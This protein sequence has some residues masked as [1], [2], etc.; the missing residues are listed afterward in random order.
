MLPLRSI[1]ITLLLFAASLFIS[2]T[3]LVPQNCNCDLEQECTNPTDGRLPGIWDDATCTCRHNTPVIIDLT[4]HGFLLTSKAN[5]VAFDIDADGHKEDIAWTDPSA[6][7]AFL[8]LDRNANG[9][10][11]DG[12]ELFGNVTPQPL[13]KTPN[14]FVAL[15][16]F[17]KPENG[18]NSDG[19][20]DKKDAV[21][22]RLRLWIDRNHDGISQPSELDTLNSHGIQSISLNYS[23]SMKRDQFGNLFRFRSRIG[24]SKQ[25]DV[26]RVAYDV[27]LATE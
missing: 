17:D 7:N 26:G 3:N 6:D 8:V 9:T 20:I 12:T 18:G 10:I 21:F 15:A 22:G 25:S 2:P 16:E 5:G 23:E 19:V 24:M 4:G 1:R 27:F 14:G 13:S 11:D